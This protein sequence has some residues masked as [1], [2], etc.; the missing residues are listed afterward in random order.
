MIHLLVPVCEAT[1]EI[2]DVLELLVGVSGVQEATAQAVGI[3]G[4]EELT[5]GW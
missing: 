3:V 2:P 5:R 4:E 1:G